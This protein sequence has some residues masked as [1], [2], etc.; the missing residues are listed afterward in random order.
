MP[1]RVY[2]KD[3]RRPINSVHLKG[4]GSWMEGS[5]G[6]QGSWEQYCLVKYVCY[7]V[8]GLAQG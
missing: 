1:S 5:L 6:Y 4:E 7:G 3:F 8:R 2:D